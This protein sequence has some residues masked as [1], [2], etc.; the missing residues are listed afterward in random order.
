MQFDVGREQRLEF[1]FEVF[2]F[3]GLASL[4]DHLQRESRAA[5][6]QDRFLRALAG[7]RVPHVHEKVVLGGSIGVRVEIDPVVHRARIH[8][9]GVV[10][11][12][13]RR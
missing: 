12:L 11:P 4:Q 5:A 9:V 2:S 13:P 8:N 6:D 7:I 1:L 3:R 10:R